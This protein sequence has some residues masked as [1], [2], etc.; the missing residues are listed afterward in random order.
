MV[1]VYDD[2][3]KQEYY[4]DGLLKQNLDVI[5]PYVLKDWD[6]CW[7]FS[8]IEGGGKSTLALQIGRY[9]S[10]A[11]FTIDHV[12]FSPEEFMA[13]IRQNDF[14][15]PGDT[16][17]LDESFMI[18][19]RA[20]MSELN[21][22]FLAIL[23]ECRQKQL[24][25]LL[26]CPNFFDLDKNLALWRSRGMFYIYHD[27]MQRGFFKYYSYD[28]KKNLYILGKKFFNYNSAKPDLLGRFTKYIPLDH[29]EYKKLKLKAFEYRPQE[30][31]KNIRHTKQRNLL[32]RFLK[33]MGIPYAKTAQYLRDNGENITDKGV[34]LAVN[35]HDENKE[36]YTNKLVDDDDEKMKDEGGQ[37]T[38]DD[39]D[40]E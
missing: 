34:S 40:L 21:R 31:K 8:G 9:L 38:V 33:E 12:C 32:F 28:K 25:L 18:N 19:S 23:S 22:K 7:I 17:L 37:D 36:H 27:A 16:L 4:I 10:G 29:D 35:R 14:L 26:C 24:F 15:Q 39:D 6:M 11:R 1:K 30:R 3:K 5:K 20:T 2:V 13:K